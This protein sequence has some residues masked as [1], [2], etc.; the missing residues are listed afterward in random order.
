M[1]TAGGAAFQELSI[2]IEPVSGA[3]NSSR[4]SFFLDGQPLIDSFNRPIVHQ[5]AHGAAATGEMNAGVY[6]KVGTANNSWTVLVDYCGAWQEALSGGVIRTPGPEPTTTRRGHKHIL[7][8]EDYRGLKRL[9][10]AHG[11]DAVEDTVRGC[12]IPSRPC[13][14]TSA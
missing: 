5:V 2:R 1:Q 7:G 10:E 14:T 13:R 8:H 3:F 12:S 11:G 6:A 4:V 9:M